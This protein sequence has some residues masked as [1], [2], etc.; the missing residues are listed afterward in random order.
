MTT[1]GVT[2][3]RRAAQL[4]SVGLDSV[5]IS[6]DSLRRDRVRRLTGFDVLKP[7]VSAIYAALEYDYKPVKVCFPKTFHCCRMLS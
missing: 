1:N 7:A 5:N 6:L 4:R 3:T 2:F